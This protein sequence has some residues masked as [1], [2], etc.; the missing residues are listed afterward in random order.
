MK[1]SSTC[2]KTFGLYLSLSTSVVIS[3]L[4]YSHEEQPAQLLNVDKA[5]DSAAKLEL[6]SKLAKMEKLSSNFQQSVFDEAGNLLQSGSG[7]LAI[8]KPNKVR[9]HTKSPEE[10]LIISDGETLWFF[11]PFIEQVS[12]HTLDN[13]IAN[14]PILLLTSEDKS[15]WQG[16]QVARVKANSYSITSNDSNSQVKNL[17][18]NFNKEEL[19]GFTITDT[20][21]QISK[22]SLSE[23]DIKS[24]LKEQLFK[25]EIPEGVY[26]DDQR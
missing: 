25:F 9:W 7:E 26:L 12:A 16:Y 15:L 17:I 4:S 6:M 3:P 13:A 24:D 5:I 1:L 20:T 22:F 11:D 10:S 14:T 19:T 18:L 23:V 2:I 8:K 21:G